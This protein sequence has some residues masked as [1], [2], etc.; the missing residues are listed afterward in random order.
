MALQAKLYLYSDDEGEDASTCTWTTIEACQTSQEEGRRYIN[1]G[2]RVYQAMK[3]IARIGWT[4]M[5]K[6]FP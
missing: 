2:I 6:Q 1:C 5:A 3:T 4:I